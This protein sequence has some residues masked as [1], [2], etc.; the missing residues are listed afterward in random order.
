[1]LFHHGMYALHVYSRCF[2]SVVNMEQL[3]CLQR[4][5]PV[6]TAYYQY[7]SYLVVD[8]FYVTMS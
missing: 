7:V 1:M 2:P 5:S 3:N 6:M 4:E 8:L